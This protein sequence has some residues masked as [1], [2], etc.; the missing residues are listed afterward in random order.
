MI[1]HDRREV[2]RAETVVLRR[3]QCDAQ[4]A[5]H[6]HEK[7]LIDAESRRERIE[8]K[9]RM[10]YSPRLILL[11]AVNDHT[12]RARVRN[13]GKGSIARIGRHVDH[14]IAAEQAVRAIVGRRKGVRPYE[15][16]GA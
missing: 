5:V 7:Q 8:I 10:T 6:P 12:I 11:V 16:I 4:N 15:A 13:V 3:R 14:H 1:R 9:I 2:Q